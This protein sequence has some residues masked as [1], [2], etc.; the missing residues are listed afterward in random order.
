MLSRSVSPLQAERLYEEMQAAMQARL[1]ACG[2]GGESDGSNS[3]QQ[4]NKKRGK[5]TDPSEIR[6]KPIT[7]VTRHEMSK[8]IARVATALCV[9][10]SEV[11]TQ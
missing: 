5:T 9:L 3:G 6:D 10:Q 11:R 4:S 2:L 1:N 8:A 7:T